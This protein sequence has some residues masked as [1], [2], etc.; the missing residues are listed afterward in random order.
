[1]IY[2]AADHAGF[3]LKEV[4]KKYLKEQGQESEDMGAFVLDSKDDYPDFIL[5]A[6]NKVAENPQ[7]NIGFLFGASGQGEAIAANKVKGIRA[8]VY[9]GGSLDLVARSRSHN[10]ANVLSLGAR[11]LTPEE[12]IDAI[13]MWMRTEFIGGRHERRIEKV[14]QFEQRG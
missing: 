10:N 13:E 5:P 4:I 14:K 6:S 12:T 2:L 1:M 9:Y 3:D 7:E 8:A 11:F